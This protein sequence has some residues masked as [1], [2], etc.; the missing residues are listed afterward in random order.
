MT[1]FLDE[2]RPERTHIPRGLNFVVLRLIPHLG[3][4]ASGT[5]IRERISAQFDEDVP[6]AKV[7]VALS[8]LEDQGL[9]SAR[10]EERR[11][12]GH[13]G[14]PRRIYELTASGLRALQAGAKLYANPMSS[15]E[16]AEDAESIT[17]A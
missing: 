12:A 17:K 11:P 5:E 16:G 4:R 3:T 13:R 8:R 1:P 9:V 15:L 7:Y 14:R 6:A 10:D 2:S